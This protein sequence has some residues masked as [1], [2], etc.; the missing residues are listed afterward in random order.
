MLNFTSNPFQP[1][2]EC[3]SHVKQKIKVWGSYLT[4]PCCRNVLTTMSKALAIHAVKT[5]GSAHVFLSQQEWKNCSGPFQKD[6]SVSAENCHFGDLYY[7]SSA[8][9]NT[10][11]ASIKTEQ[12]FQNAIRKCANLSNAFDDVCG[13]CSKAV[14]GLRDSLLK[15]YGVKDGNA[16]E[17]GICGI[18]AVIS[19]LEEKMNNTLLIDNDYM[20]CMSLLDAFGMKT[21]SASCLLNQLPIGPIFFF[22]FIC[23]IN[24][25]FHV[26]SLSVHMQIQATSNSNVSKAVLLFNL[27]YLVKIDNKSSCVLKEINHLTYQILWQ[28][29]YFQS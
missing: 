18:A 5:Q 9:S 19:V 13:Y 26:Y 8:C 27:L 22:D 29:R 23:L 17:T 12:A 14:L 16:T 15:T 7:G 4:S 3:L 28:K 25:L 20:S 11:L 6:R 24:F 1:T 10:T 2:G 21:A